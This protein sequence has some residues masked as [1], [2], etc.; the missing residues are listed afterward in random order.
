MGRDADGDQDI[1]GGMARGALALP[2]QPDLLAFDHAD[3]N[4]DIQL[5]ARRQPDALLAALD[6][7]FERNGHGGV[8]VEVDPDPAG[9][10]LELATAAGA[11]PRAAHSAAKHAVEDVL[12]RARAGSTAAAT[13]AAERIALE[14]AGTGPAACTTAAR[15][16]LE[17]RLAVGADLAAV[18]LLALV[19]VAEDLVGRVD[20]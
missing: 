18:E 16:A 8:D 2:P 10:E 14:A 3:R 1:A 13:T 17:A 11:G 5:L 6:R 4:P 20:L 12:E 15:K 7:L 9:V 19:L